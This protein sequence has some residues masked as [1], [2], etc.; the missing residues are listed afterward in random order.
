MSSIEEQFHMMQQQIAALQEQPNGA[1]TPMKSADNTAPIPLHSMGTRPHYDWSPSDT[2]T[3]L[4]NLD[5]PLYTSTLLSDSESAF[6]PLDI[7]SHELVSSESGN[8][9]LERYCIMLRDVRKLLLHVCFA[10][11][12]ARNNIALRAVNP[13]FSLKQDQKIQYTLPLDEFQNTLSYPNIL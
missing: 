11:R 10:M 9:N 8:P 12:Q 2:L 6:R 1:S 4:M 13:S 7:L 5:T 3:E